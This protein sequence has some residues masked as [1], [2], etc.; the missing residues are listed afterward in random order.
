M[1]QVLHKYLLSIVDSWT[2]QFELHG[3]LNMWTF[4]PINNTIVLY[5]PQLV[6]SKHAELQVKRA[7]IKLG[8]GFP[9]QGSSVPLSPALL[10]GQLYFRSSL[11]TKRDRAHQNNL[12]LRWGLNVTAPGREVSLLAEVIWKCSQ[13]K[14]CFSWAWQHRGSCWDPYEC[15]SVLGSEN[16]RSEGT[17]GESSICAFDR[18]QIVIS[19]MVKYVL[20][21]SLQIFKSQIKIQVSRLSWKI[22]PDNW[23]APRSDSPFKKICAFA[24]VCHRPHLSPLHLKNIYT[25]I[26]LASSGLPF[27]G[28]CMHAQLCLTLGTLWTVAH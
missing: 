19:R 27:G 20:W 9:L 12:D 25:C 26:Y 15:D 24:P 16:S 23:L 5:D 18:P 14:W 1:K 13:K 2:T 8:V 3:P 6:E 7:A 10:Q 4:F 28:I 21:I 11:S 17:E 22:L